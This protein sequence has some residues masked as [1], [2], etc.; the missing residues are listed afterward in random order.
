MLIHSIRHCPPILHVRQK[1]LA[2][3]Q[4]P[5]PLYSIFTFADPAIELAYNIKEFSDPDSR[6]AWFGFHLLCGSVTQC[7]TNRYPRARALGGSTIHNAMINIIAGTQTD[8]DDIST[9][10]EDASWTR[11]N[12]QEYFKKIEKNLYLLP[13]LLTLGDHGFTGWLKTTLLP[14][15][16]L[17]HNLGE[18]QHVS[19]MLH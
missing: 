16:S 14:Y 1:V 15:L 13:T 19:K 10:F 11:S 12:M 6:I 4:L 2:H 3:P 7:E 17:L 8:F 9:N 18:L 5:P